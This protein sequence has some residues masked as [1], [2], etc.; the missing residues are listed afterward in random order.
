MPKPKGRAKIYPKTTRTNH[1]ERRAA[2]DVKFESP[3]ARKADGIINAGDHKIGWPIAVIRTM[4]KIV[5][6]ISSGALYIFINKGKNG[7]IAAE[8]TT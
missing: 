5:W 7:M 1:I 4:I 3:A 8:V 6:I 2:I